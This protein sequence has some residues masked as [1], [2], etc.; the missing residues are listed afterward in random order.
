MLSIEWLWLIW[1]T[2]QMRPTRHLTESQHPMATAL[3]SIGGSTMYMEVYIIIV[4]AVVI[5][6]GFGFFPWA[7]ARLLNTVTGIRLK[8][9][10]KWTR[11]RNL[12]HFRTQNHTHFK[13]PGFQQRQFNTH[14]WE[15][16]V[17][18]QYPIFMPKYMSHNATVPHRWGCCSFAFS[19]T[20]VAVSEGTCEPSRSSL[21]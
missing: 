15:L 2:N 4:V 16:C 10:S 14:Q 11:V 19:Q 13:V 21:V 3:L 18:Y 7:F 9:F 8:L 12:A 6:E 5:F 17:S 1:W 20:S